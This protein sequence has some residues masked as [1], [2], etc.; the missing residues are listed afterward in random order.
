MHSGALC[1][2]G[3]SFFCFVY[4]IPSIHWTFERNGRERLVEGGMTEAKVI[5]QGFERMH[6]LG[7]HGKNSQNHHCVQDCSIGKNSD[8]M[9]WNFC[10]KE[11]L[12][13]ISHANDTPLA[14]AIPL[15]ERSCALLYTLPINSRRVSCRRRH[16]YEEGGINPHFTLRLDGWLRLTCKR[17]H[18]SSD[19]SFPSES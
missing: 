5:P 13:W 1:L 12:E 7:V 3:Q 4:L 11:D 14:T 17:K 18:A 10:L 9:L 16:T 6:S 2:V 8:C 19:P 15:P